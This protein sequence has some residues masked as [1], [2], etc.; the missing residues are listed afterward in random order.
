MYSDFRQCS[1]GTLGK[2]AKSFRLV[3]FRRLTISCKEVYDETFC[4]VCTL[5]FAAGHKC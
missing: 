2:G 1:A 4:P 5:P 3:R